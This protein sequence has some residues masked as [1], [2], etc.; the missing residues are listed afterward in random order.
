MTPTYCS[1]VAEPIQFITDSSNFENSTFWDPN[2]TSG[3]GGWGD[4][5]NDIEITDGGFATGFHLS[6]P[7]HHRL[8]RRFTPIAS[9]RPF[10][11]VETFTPASQMAIVN[12]FVGNF[13]DF[14]ASLELGSHSSV[15]L[16]MGGY[17]ISSEHSGFAHSE[18]TEISGGNAPQ[19]PQLIA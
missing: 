4:P 1:R 8:R 9:I 7:S 19:T 15:H 3:I 2:T 10:P 16:I 14:Q 5:N 12:G 18:P 11:L 13:P 17:V 6:Y